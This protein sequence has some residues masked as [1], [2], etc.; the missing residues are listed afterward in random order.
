[1]GVTVKIAGLRDLEKSLFGLPKATQKNVVRR[2]LK[3]A[4]E[5]IRD[6]ARSDAPVARGILKRSIA[7]STKL[8]KRQARIN[9]GSAAKKKGSI[10][11]FIGAGNYPYAHMQEFGTDNLPRQAFLGPAF[12]QNKTRVLTKIIKDMQIE[13]DKAAKRLAKKQAKK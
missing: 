11:V 10:Q 12:D 4:G 6:D 9:R 2:V 8:S 7:V 13:I 1:M 5:P 3:K